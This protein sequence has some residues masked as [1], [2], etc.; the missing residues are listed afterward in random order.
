MP[1]NKTDID[2]M[3]QSQQARTMNLKKWREQ[4]LHEVELPSGLQILIRDVDMAS[5]I[6]EGNIPNM[7][8]ELIGSDEFQKMPEKEVG[9]KIL[10]DNKADFNTMMREVIK[11]SLVEPTIGD[12]ADD[13]HIL[14]SELTFEDKMVI[15]NFVNREAQA[16][17]SFRDESK[18]PGPAA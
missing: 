12:V 2:R 6:I 7:L 14:Y 17:R 5:I 10:T 13:K 16:V 3:N 1:K 18:E 9:E 4:R 15:F 11:A 8:I